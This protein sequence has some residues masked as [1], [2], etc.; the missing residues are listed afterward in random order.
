VT[1][2]FSF[3]LPTLAGI[4]LL[5]LCAGPALAFA[6]ELR[7][8]DTAAVPEPASMVLLGSG[9]V[10]LAGLIHRRWKN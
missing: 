4:V 9:L 6:R 5:A 1:T 2:K 10:G 8:G 7:I 3:L